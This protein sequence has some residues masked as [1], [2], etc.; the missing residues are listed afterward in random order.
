MAQVHTHYDNLKVARNAPPEVIRAAYRTLSQKYHPDRNPGD[1][2]AT[3][4]MKLINASYAVLSDPSKREEHDIWIAEQ[5][6]RLSANGDFS[7]T[8][9]RPKSSPPVAPEGFSQKIIRAIRRK[10]ST[11][12]R[13]D[14]IVSGGVAIFIILTWLS[15][16]AERP[17]K[18]APAV[19]SRGYVA[20]PERPQ[21]VRPST[22]PNGSPWPTSGS[23][24]NGY[25]KSHTNGLSKVTVD[26]SRNDSD[27]FVKLVFLDSAQA[28]SV[29]V[30][31]IP[32]HSSYTVNNVRVGNYDVRYLNLSSG[33]ISRTEPF[34]L[35]ERETSN[36]R[37]YSEIT[38][39]LYKVPRGNMKTYDISEEEF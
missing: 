25:K 18:K 29:R 2:E 8:M 31:F 19:A 14:W 1:L 39:T 15:S 36:G 7:A 12:L 30:F 13:G 17:G 11:S 28:Y 4:I 6:E 26:N 22:A 23:Y 20:E 24:V 10:F 37:Q 21:Y 27:V 9:H 3:R 38:M 33:G 34:L 5:E 16:P 32:A 35:E